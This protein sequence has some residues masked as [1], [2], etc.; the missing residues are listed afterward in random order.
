[1]LKSMK[2]L[3][4]FTLTA[5]I[6]FAE[7][8]TKITVEGSTLPATVAGIPWIQVTNYG[9]RGN[10]DQGM[11]V[12][13]RGDDMKIDIY[14]YDSLNPDWA[15]L[16][17]QQKIKRENESIAG[18]FKQFTDNGDYSNVKMKPMVLVQQGGREFMHTEMNFTD[19][20]AGDLN[21]HYYL[22]ELNGRIL[23]IRISR[24]V[25]SDP[26]SAES[27]FM[28]IASALAKK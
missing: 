11:S 15:K 5:V 2:F 14:V 27:A 13:Y 16:P 9:A 21:S 20:K 25:D 18:I 3:A 24:Q 4:L 23:K 8:S 19:K 22:A 7:V 17:I 6:S 28:E 1:M 26:A 10:P 12:S